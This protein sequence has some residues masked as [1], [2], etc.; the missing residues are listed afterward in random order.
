ML[1]NRRITFRIVQGA[2]LLGLAACGGSE[3]SWVMPTPTEEKV[4][5]PIQITGK[6]QYYGFEGGFYAIRGN[7]GVTYDPT[8]LP[9]T[10]RKDGLAV[11]AEARL[12]EGIGNTHMAGPIVALDRIRER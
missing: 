12:L 10:F 2:F 3:A 7:D 9:A 11:E 1:G 8:N 5:T 6:V 4:G